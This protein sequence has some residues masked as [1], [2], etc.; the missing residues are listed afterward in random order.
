MITA[1]KKKVA[2]FETIIENKSFKTKVLEDQGVP[3]F[4][5]RTMISEMSMYGSDLML[6]SI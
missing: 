4:K 2:V 3:V 5:F 6:E 1:T